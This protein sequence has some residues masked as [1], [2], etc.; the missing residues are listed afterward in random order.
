M[1]KLSLPVI[2][3][4]L[5]NHNKVRSRNI[6]VVLEVAEEGDSLKSLAETLYAKKK[7]QSAVSL[8]AGGIET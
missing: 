3:C 2:E 1:S 8:L 4:R 5:W 6:A 7:R